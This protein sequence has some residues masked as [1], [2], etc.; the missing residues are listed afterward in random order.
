MKFGFRP[1]PEVKIRPGFSLME[2]LTVTIIIGL[3]AAVTFPLL[4]SYRPNLTAKGGAQQLET[5]MHKARFRAANQ[6]TPVRLVINCSHPGGFESCFL[7]LQT[8]VY[9]N[10]DVT[11]WNREPGDHQILNRELM[12]VRKNP[13]SVHDGQISVKD[14]YWTIFMPVGHVY[15]DPRP[16]ELFLYHTAQ[17]NSSK[18]GWKISVNSENGR[19]ESLRDSQ[20]VP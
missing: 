15:S 4:S 3:L 19:V 9:T 11:G 5:M 1:G 2:L 12:V 7:D 6:K 8:A 10:N 16:L 17:K 18:R 20:T 14:I 13:A